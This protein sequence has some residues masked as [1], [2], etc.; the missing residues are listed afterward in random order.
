MGAFELRVAWVD[1]GDREAY[2][3]L[4]SVAAVRKW[5][6]AM[7]RLGVQVDDTELADMTLVR[8]RLMVGGFWLGGVPIIAFVATLFIWWIGLEKPL[9]GTAIIVGFVAAFFAQCGLRLLALG[10]HSRRTGTIRR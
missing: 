10:I 5:L 4:D 9:N 6:G 8:G 3:P 7:E 2:V 1:D